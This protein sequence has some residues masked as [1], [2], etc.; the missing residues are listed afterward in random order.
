[1]KSLLRKYVPLEARKRI[2][3]MRTFFKAKFK[4]S[5]SQSGEDMILNTILSKVRNGVYVDVGANNPT[6]QSNTRF[7]YEKGWSGINIDALPGSMKRFKR[8]RS[9]DINLEIPISDTEEEL[10][11]YMFS[12]SF[13]NSF[14]AEAAD[15]YKDK[16]IGKMPLQT[17]R[18][19][20]VLQNYLKDREIDFMSID[21][22]GLDFQ[23]LKSNDWVRYRP[24][25]ILFESHAYDN[26]FLRDNELGQFL[27]DNGYHFFCF[28]PTNVFYIENEFAKSRFESE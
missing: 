12:S 6:V 19:S 8:Y 13:Y 21:V 27:T 2:F 3:E 17:K 20:W 7:F 28:S 10:T 22:E 24:K 5:Y 11:Y 16:L 15:R 9:R 1:M 18:L 23:V 26:G 25:V 4:R 14:S